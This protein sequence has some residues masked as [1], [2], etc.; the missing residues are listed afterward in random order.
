[1]GLR[2]EIS[3]SS[4]FLAPKPQERIATVPCCLTS[5][6]HWSKVTS[7][8]GESIIHWRIWWGIKRNKYGKLS[9]S[10]RKKASFIDQLVFGSPCK[11]VKRVRVTSFTC[12]SVKDGT[13][14][15]KNPC[16]SITTRRASQCKYYFSNSSHI[17]ISFDR[18]TT[19]TLSSANV[20]LLPPTPPTYPLSG[21][22]IS[23]AHVTWAQSHKDLQVIFFLKPTRRRMG[24]ILWW[25]GPSGQWISSVETVDWSC[26]LFT[27][28]PRGPDSALHPLRAAHPSNNPSLSHSRLYVI[29][30]RENKTTRNRLNMK[31]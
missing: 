7:N 15:S 23:P 2:V 19:F 16:P 29:Y 28:N 25:T 11:Y 10:H 9:P 27:N 31:T 13:W 4:L 20:S 22:I 3:V 14:T 6:L 8:I 1:M 5:K 17:C 12:P 30:R 21:V 26:Y 24:N 18:F